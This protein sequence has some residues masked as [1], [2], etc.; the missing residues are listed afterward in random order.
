M[1]FNQS[2]NKIYAIDFGLAKR[3]LHPRTMEHIPMTKHGGLIGTARF[4][5]INAH[6]GL[7]QSRRDDMIAV[8]YLLVFL[9]K[10]KL[11]WQKVRA[12]NK[13][14][15]HDKILALK[16]SNTPDVLCLGLPGKNQKIILM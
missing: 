3:Y 16:Q 6:L 5:S 4:A 11:P 8:G 10:G 9:M 14:R 12:K 1:G 15:K 7:E 2:I 13:Q